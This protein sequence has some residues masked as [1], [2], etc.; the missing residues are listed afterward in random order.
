MKHLT[1][2]K[3]SV[4]ER[5]RRQLCVSKFRAAGIVPKCN[6]GGNLVEGCEADLSTVECLYSGQRYEVPVEHLT[7][8]VAFIGST[9][10]EGC[11]GL[12]ED[13]MHLELGGDLLPNLGHLDSCDAGMISKTAAMIVLLELNFVADGMNTD[14]HR[15]ISAH[16]GLLL[17]ERIG[18]LRCRRVLGESG[19]GEAGG[20]GGHGQQRGEDGNARQQLLHLEQPP[21]IVNVMLHQGVHFLVGQV[22]GIFGVHAAQL[23]LRLVEEALAA[24]VELLGD[25]RQADF[26]DGSV[27]NTHFLVFDCF[28]QEL[29]KK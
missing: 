17:D 16:E 24:Q 18:A 28:E 25:D 6:A 23:L 27:L 11:Q 14:G 21:L 26:V 5:H 1:L 13:E 15:P 2:H 7:D 3:V 20:Q 12:D 4:G 8:W 9:I 19:G 29:K 22:A 10:G